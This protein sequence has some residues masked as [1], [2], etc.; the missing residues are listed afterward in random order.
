MQSPPTSLDF[1]DIAMDMATLDR[2]HDIY[3][4]TSIAAG[5]NEYQPDPMELDLAPLS[6]MRPQAHTWDGVE[7]FKA[8]QGVGS[9]PQR[10]TTTCGACLD[11]TNHAITIACGCHYCLPCFNNFFE[12]NLANRESFPPKC[13][14]KEIALGAVREHLHTAVLKRYED[15]REEFGSKN[16][17]YCAVPH[18]S[19]FLAGAVVFADFK[20]CPKCSQQTCI[21]CKNLRTLHEGSDEIG[22][23][24]PGA[25]TAAHRCP[26]IAIPPELTAL[27]AKEKWSRCPGCR[28]IVEK[29]DGCDFMECICD[30]EFCYKCSQTFEGGETCGCPDNLPD[31]ERAGETEEE[32]DEGGEDG[33][34]PH[35]RA[36]VDAHGRIRCMHERTSPLDDD[37]DDDDG[38][39]ARCHGCLQEM[40][41]VRSCDSCQLELCGE[42][43]R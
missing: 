20:A 31:E 2:E 30:E 8:W 39:I 10:A 13:C 38:G 3:L 40:P 18:C 14:G 1:N 32:L 33:E 4:E 5:G 43:L 36:A 37:G 27:V 28:H 25:S 21:R 26:G 12:S 42:C 11:F 23:T 34:W 24:N 7:P 19:T 17:T 15:V 9:G 16:P 29:I 22:E 41:D 35:Y 6:P